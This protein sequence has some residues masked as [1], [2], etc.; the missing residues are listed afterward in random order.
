MTNVRMNPPISGVHI[1]SDEGHANAG[2]W[3][4]AKASEDL[5]VSM[6]APKKDEILSVYCPLKTKTKCRIL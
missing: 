1:L 6:T 5:D 3:I 2:Q 4:H